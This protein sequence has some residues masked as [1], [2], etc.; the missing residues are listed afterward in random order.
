MDVHCTD[1][2][3]TGDLVHVNWRR[4]QVADGRTFEKDGVCP[5]VLKR[6]KVTRVDGPSVSVAGVGGKKDGQEGDFRRT[7]PS[8]RPTQ[9]VRD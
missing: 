4:G 2:G 6:A 7:Y 1:N 8:P 9:K 5:P 3:R